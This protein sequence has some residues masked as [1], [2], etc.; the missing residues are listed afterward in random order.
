MASR[1]RRQLRQSRAALAL[2]ARLLAYLRSELRALVL[3]ITVMIAATLL[4][5]G[6]P[7]PM[8]VVVDSVLGSQPPPWWLTRPL[9]QLGAKELL[10]AATGL[11][12]AALALGI[13]LSLGQQYF[14]HLLGQR[15]VLRLRCDLY[16]KLQRLSLQFHDR[17]NLGD[18]IYRITGDSAALQDVV[19]YGLVPLSIQLTTATLIAGTIFL[20][21]ARLGWASVSVVPLLLAWT[22]WFSERVRRRSRRLANADSRLYTTV[23]E[24][25]GAI[26]AVK[27]FGMEGAELARFTAHARS[28]QEAYVDV[29]TVSAFGGLVTNA[30]SGVGVTAVIFLGALAVLDR[31]L[32]VGQLLVFLAYLHA[33][34]EPVT[35]LASSAMVVQRSAASIERVVEILDEEDEEGRSGGQTLSVVSGRIS[36]DHVGMAYEANRPVLHEVNLEVR[37]GEMVAFV[38]QSGTGKTT[39]MS[40]L[41]RFYRPQSGHLLLDGVDITMLDLAWL[42]QQIAIVLQEPI[43]FS[44]SLAEN[45]AYGRAGASRRD[46]ERAGEA[47]GLHDFIRDLPDG[48][49][50]AVG[51][52]GVRLSGGQRQRLSIAR[53]FLKDAPIL[54]LDEPTSNLD[55]TTERHIFESI[56][57]LARGRTTLVVSHRLVTARRADRIVVLAGGRIVE[58]GQHEA[59]LSAG[60]AYARLYRDQ[61]GHRAASAASLREARA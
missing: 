50:T 17:S 44:S 60:G 10:A 15:M 13:V 35:Q 37:P 27:S 41:L 33:L 23:S 54:L 45:I 36:F 42:R 18:L 59:L 48:Y 61:A 47:A 28:S 57:R 29:M 7:W 31:Q 34:Y 40:L 11:M 49:E 19:V 52:R 22:V 56:D 5:L 39:L 46:I 58:Q 20:L 9:G 6:R 14:S 43:I 53:A 21:D 8:Q 24:V 1:V 2:Y 3:T 26:R 38:G 12:V 55:A 51:E 4:T 25:L 32:T 16:A 30:L